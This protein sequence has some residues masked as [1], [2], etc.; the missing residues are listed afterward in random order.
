MKLKTLFL[1]LGLVLTSFLFSPEVFS[2]SKVGAGVG[3]KPENPLD[4]RFNSWFMY[5][6]K[7]G[8][9][10]NDT[11]II[12]NTTKEEWMAYV[13]P[14]DWFPAD[15]GGFHL[16]QDSEKMEEMG[17][18][19]KFPQDK[20][21]LGPGEKRVLPFTITLPADASPDEICGGIAVEKNDSTNSGPGMRLYTRNAVRVFNNYVDGTCT[22]NKIEKKI[23]ICHKE[24][25][26]SKTI[27]IPESALSGHLDHGDTRGA[28]VTEKPKP[29]LPPAPKPKE[30]KYKEIKNLPPG[31]PPPKKSGNPKDKTPTSLGDKL[32]DAKDRLFPSSPKDDDEGFRPAAP[33]IPSGPSCPAPE[34]IT[35]CDDSG[36]SSQT[37]TIE[38]K[39]I[40]KYSGA[41]LGKCETTAPIPDNCHYHPSN[42]RNLSTALFNPVPK[43]GDAEATCNAKKD[44]GDRGYL[45]DMAGEKF[46]DLVGGFLRSFLKR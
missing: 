1:G 7:P 29:P 11:I 5:T 34:K 31:P 45:K 35:I 19:I 39:D 12:S 41:T 28:C 36:D 37:R 15:G 18:W 9:T 24:G 23:Q 21:L 33:K 44:N 42:P 13:Y 43:W 32:K 27:T 4:S 6:L 25:E 3:G 14:T 17:A 38:P 10:Y 22:G 30:P 8:E 46:W 2:D 20:V 16:K 40:V 26:K